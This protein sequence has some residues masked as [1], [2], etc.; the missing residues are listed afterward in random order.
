LVPRRLQGRNGPVLPVPTTGPSSEEERG[1]DPPYIMACQ[2]GGEKRLTPTVAGRGWTFYINPRKRPLRSWADRERILCRYAKRELPL[3]WQEKKRSTGGGGISR[4]DQR[5]SG[6]VY[7]EAAGGPRLGSEKQ[8]PGT[9]CR[10]RNSSR[11]PPLPIG[12]EG[13]KVLFVAHGLAG[14]GHDLFPMAVEKKTREKG[15]KRAV[16]FMAFPRR[17]RRE[18]VVGG[19]R[20]GKGDAKLSYEQISK[21]RKGDNVLEKGKREGKKE[22]GTYFS[23]TKREQKEKLFSGIALGNVGKEKN[24]PKKKLF[25]LRV[26]ECR[27]KESVV[28]GN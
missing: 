17:T 27:E 9:T 15:G 26:L 28:T 3:N 23:N 11:R 2:E 1:F 4:V 10:K 18:F 24:R 7:A 20:E 6:K 8:E 5:G 22:T 21:K 13:K 25:R 12:G 16:P 19:Q 14:G